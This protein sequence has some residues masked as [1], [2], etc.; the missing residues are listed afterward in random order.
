MKFLPFLILLAFGQAQSQTLADTLERSLNDELLKPWYPQALDTMDGGFLSSFTY[1]M[2]PTGK[3]DKFIVTQARH[4]W[5]TAQVA[6]RH[7][8]NTWFKHASLAGFRFLRDKMWDKKDGGFFEMVTKN[9]TPINPDGT[10]TAYGNAFGIYALAACFKATHDPEVLKLAQTAF[11]WMEAHSHDRK[12]NGYFQHLA[13]N[14]APIQR[15]VNAPVESDIGL[16]DQNSSIHLLE[17]LTALYEVWPDPLVKTRLQ[18]M[19]LLVRDKIVSSKGYLILFLKPDWTPITVR[20]SSIEYITTHHRLDY[21]SFGHDI[22]TAFLM[23]E[24]ETALGIRNHQKTLSIGKKMLDHAL[25]TGYDKKLG[26]FF[27]EG[28][29]FKGADTITILRHTKNWWAQAEGMNT[30]LLMS[31]YFP[32]DRHHYLERFHQQWNYINT[33]LIDHNHGDWYEGGIDEEPEKKTTLKGHIW[34]GTYHN[35]RALTSCIEQL[36]AAKL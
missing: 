25:D 9:G 35:Y 24:A 16:K 32:N 12:L 14:G 7:P 23:L 31:H 15:P 29:Y 5:V 3:Q 18:E 19:L 13:R 34:K 27:D 30:L 26:G 20:D 33:Y 2:K 11:R 10:K 28:Y 8:E 21:V 36:R 1:D 4:T 22:E 6:M 17:A